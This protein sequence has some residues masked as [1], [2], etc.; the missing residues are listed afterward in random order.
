MPEMAETVGVSKSQVSR[1]TIEAGER[2]LQELAERD[3]SG[4]DIL[5]VWADGIQLGAYHVICAVGVDDAGNKHVLG[6]REGSTENADLHRANR[7]VSVALK[8]LPHSLPV[9]PL[10][11]A[12]VES[13]AR[14]VTNVASIFMAQASSPSGS[15]CAHRPSAAM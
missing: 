2:L 3:F 10:E 9:P 13:T 14:R 8:H 5:A 7:S 6:L 15:R 11:A 1:E 12:W 4:L